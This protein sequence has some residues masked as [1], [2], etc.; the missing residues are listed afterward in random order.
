MVQWLRPACTLPWSRAVTA[1]QGRQSEV[2]S[3]H[4][5][6]PLCGSQALL[7]QDPA[8]NKSLGSNE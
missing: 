6:L 2:Q 3:G 8:P 5:D 7:H 1:L 4:L